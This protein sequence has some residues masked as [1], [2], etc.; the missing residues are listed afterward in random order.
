MARMTGTY[1]RSTVAEESVEAFV[2][3]PPPPREPPLDLVGERALLLAQANES[4]RLLTVNRVIE[5]LDC[6]RPAAGKAVRVLAAAG[7]VRRLDERKKNRT[8]VFEDY[9]ALLRQ[10]TELSS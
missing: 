8:V 6:S 2:P 5:L 1:E 7:I 10:G 3:C 9:L 4:I